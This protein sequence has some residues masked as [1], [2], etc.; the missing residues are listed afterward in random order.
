M[1]VSGDGQLD[2]SELKRAF[3]IAGRPASDEAIE[4][5]IRALDKDNDGLVSFDEFQAIAWQV[6]IEGSA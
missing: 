6:A 4:K 2:H 3:E 5:A 1:D